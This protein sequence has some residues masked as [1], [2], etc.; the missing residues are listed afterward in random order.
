MAEEEFC[1]QYVSLLA[2][3]IEEWKSELRDPLLSPQV[4]VVWLSKWHIALTVGTFLT[5]LRLPLYAEL[6]LQGQ[7]GEMNGTPCPPLSAP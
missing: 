4:K 7:A 6:R 3:G 5:A 1:S 2:R